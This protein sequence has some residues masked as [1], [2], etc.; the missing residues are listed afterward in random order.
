MSEIFQSIPAVEGVRKVGRDEGE[1]FDVAGAHLVWK[2]KAA[3][4]AYSFS[5]NEMT[6]ALGSGNDIHRAQEYHRNLISD[7]KIPNKYN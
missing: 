6:L 7:S 1:S 5:V 3:D 2:V 4:S